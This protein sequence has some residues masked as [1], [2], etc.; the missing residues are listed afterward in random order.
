MPLYITDT[1]QLEEFVAFARTCDVVA[2]DTEFL[3]ERCY[4][5]KLC[6]IQLGTDERSVVVDP[7]KV[8]DLSPL[9]DLMVDTSVVKVFHAATQDLDILFHELDV[10]PDPI[11]DTQVAAALLGQTVQVGYGT[12]VLNE[13]GVRLK[14]ADSFTDWARRPLS[15]SQINYALE[16][17]VYLPRIYRQLTERLEALGR[18]S[19]LEH[20]FAELVDPSR[21]RVDPE[22]RWRHL[23]NVNQLSGRQLACAK[24]VAAWRERKAMERNIPR[25]AVLS[26]VQIVEI[27][28]REPRLIDDMFMVRGVA[29]ALSTKEARDVLAACK[30]G[31]ETPDD[32]C[33]SLARAPRG[34]QNVD[35]Q[36]ALLAALVHQRA[37]ENSI[38]FS[39]ITSNAELARIARGHTD[40]CDLL[41]G[42]R[43]AIAG[44]DVLK[45]MAGKFTLTIKDGQLRV[46]KRRLR[47]GKPKDPTELSAAV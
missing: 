12:L 33:P 39:A 36:T 27:C 3:R 19:W 26:D 7:L 28:R 14:K 37:R 9:R 18:A 23:K 11:F 31:L 43:R 40:D 17:V 10:M 25:K 41:K 24:H 5:A 8:H 1:K 42:W 13:C 30:K 45:L 15:S 16:D 6:L 34:E 29:S 35:A 20:D 2:I 21:Y 46:S 38:A 44:K 47:S 32:E 22:N 4:W